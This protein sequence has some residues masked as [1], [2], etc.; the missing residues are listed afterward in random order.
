MTESSITLN[1]LASFCKVNA[2]PFKEEK[3]EVLDEYL[4][5]CTWGGHCYLGGRYKLKADDVI[6][7]ELINDA[8]KVIKK[9]ND[10]FIPY[11]GFEQ[12]IA[13]NSNRSYN[14]LKN[15]VRIAKKLL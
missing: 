15:I 7:D 14:T 5:E 2:E 8:D 13:I 10:E 4:R 6:T 3:V 11:H 9:H 12:Q 1:W